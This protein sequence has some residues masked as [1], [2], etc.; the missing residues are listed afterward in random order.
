[1]T[2]IRNG[3]G[4][5]HLLTP[6]SSPDFLGIISSADVEGLRNAGGQGLTHPVAMLA[7]SPSAEQVA[8]NTKQ[9]A[10]AIL[11]EDQE[12]L[13]ALKP[14]LL[15]NTDFSNAS[16]ALGEIRCYGALLETGMTVLPKPKV[17]N[18]KAVPE[19]EVSA[20]DGPVIVE[21][22]SRQLEE[23][24]R[25]SV[26]RHY[27][28]F[29]ARHKASVEETQKSGEDSRVVTTGVVTVA[30][31][32]APQPKKEGDSILTN[33]VSR[34]ASIKQNEKQID[35]AKPFV[36]WLDLQDPTVWGTSIAE[37]QLA[38]LYSESKGGEVSSGAL[39]FA[40]Y[41]R[42]GDPMIIMNGLDYKVQPMLHDGRFCRETLVSAVIYALPRAIILMEHPATARPIPAKFRAA[43]LRT[44]FF[45]P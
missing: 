12:W 23:S 11:R 6:N 36:L 7:L 24:G 3:S 43:L 44:P 20:G 33:A 4:G 30:P 1:V 2:Q 45:P 18:S 32:G 9:S 34:I 16:S 19:F 10:N 14:R 28:D 8:T 35:P 13:F 21:V 38:P 15:D 17:A 25:L 40:L 26:I 5:T 22:H 39:W 37:E 31:F 29:D 27:E 41:G 42:K